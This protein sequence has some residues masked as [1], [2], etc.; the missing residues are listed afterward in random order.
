MTQENVE[1]TRRAFDAFNRRDLDAF[2]A[3]MDDD[4]EAVPRAGAI[5]GESSFR[6]H[7]GVRRWWERTARC[8][9]PDFLAPDVISRPPDGWPEP[10]PFMGK[11]AVV[12]QCMQLRD[13]WNADTLELIS[14][15]IDVGDR[16]VVR[17]IWHG[18]PTCW[19]WPATTTR[20]APAT[21]RRPDAPP[22]NPRGATS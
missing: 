14:D 11:E 19:R 15:F 6:G 9:S 20:R 13:T 16:V 12:R 8:F 3:L 1:L 4:V 21:K 10:G 2:L 22:A 7:D 18:G 17:V 5:E